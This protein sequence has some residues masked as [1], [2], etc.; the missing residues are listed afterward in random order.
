MF[1]GEFEFAGQEHFYLETH[2][3]LAPVDESGQIFVQSSTQHP[4]ETQEIIAHV[5]GVTQLTR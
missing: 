5:L 4:S 2:A 1:E 3:A